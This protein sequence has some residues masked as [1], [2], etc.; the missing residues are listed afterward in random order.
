MQNLCNFSLYDLQQRYLQNS[1]EYHEYLSYLIY[2][3]LVDKLY[4]RITDLIH[5]D[6]TIAFDLNTILTS[7][8]FEEQIVIVKRIIFIISIDWNN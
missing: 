7:I 2:G 6:Y 4:K 3:F 1:T 8:I 5:N